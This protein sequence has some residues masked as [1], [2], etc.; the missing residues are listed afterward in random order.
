MDKGRKRGSKGRKRGS[1]GRKKGPRSGLDNLLH[2]FYIMDNVVYFALDGRAKEEGLFAMVSAD[3]WC[4]VSRYRWYLSKAGYPMCY[5]PKM[6]LHQFIY[7]HIWGESSPSRMCIDHIDRNKLNNTDTNLRL[8]T[9]QENS[10]NKTTRTNRK[11]VKKISDNNFVASITKD[12]IKH[13]IK[14]IPTAERAAEIYNVMAE[15]LFG[16]FAAPN[17]L[18]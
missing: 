14:N 12:G 9:P 11:G 2:D 6:K 3:K 4:Y 18:D 17:K 16:T 8:A 5:Y 7:F 13:E 1:K 10:F 15:E